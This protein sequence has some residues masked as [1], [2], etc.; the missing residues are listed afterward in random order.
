M[1]IPVDR[2]RIARQARFGS[3]DHPVLAQHTIDQRRLARIRPPDDCEL[4]DRL[5]AFVDRLVIIVVR[6]RAFEMR[7]QRIEQIA[8]PFVML[9]R[10][11]HRITKAERQGFKHS[12]LGGAAL[13]LVGCKHDRTIC[14]SQPTRDVLVK[15]YDTCPRVDHE[16]GNVCPGNC[17]FRLPAHSARQC[18]RIIL[19]IPGR[20]DD[21]EIETR[22]MR[23]A[24]TPVACNARTV[25][26]QRQAL[27]DQ[28]IEKCRLA[29][30]WAADNRDDRKF[31]H[32]AR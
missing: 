14:R 19:F 23:I 13:G 15:R 7:R 28:A 22:Q 21:S 6:Y 27:A 2:D 3:R 20:I 10:Q 12:L 17:H 4:Q 18:T 24:L 1:P 31:R 30:V 26:D 11:L 8:H 9:G 32:G 29:D 25:V 5:F 16:Q